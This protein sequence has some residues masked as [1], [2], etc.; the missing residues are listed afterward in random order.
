MRCE[1]RILASRSGWRPRRAQNARWSPTI[2][3]PPHDHAAPIMRSIGGEEIDSVLT[4][5]A[6]ID[7]LEQAFRADIEVPP[8]HH[9]AI[10]RPGADATLL[11]M[12]AWTRAD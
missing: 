10:A 6:L 7:A 1:P 5:P 8:R 2:G 9:H 11:L 4:Y 3:R 12:P